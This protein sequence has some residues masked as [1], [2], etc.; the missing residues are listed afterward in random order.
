MKEY[1][2]YDIKDNELCV[3][4]GNIKEIADF[5]EC[6]KDS[7]RSWISN[8]KNKKRN[9]L[10]KKRYE[11]VE[12]IEVEEEK[13]KTIKTDK[14][15]FQEIIKAF[16]IDIYELM[17]KFPKYN[18]TKR[19]FN[20]DYNQEAD[21]ED[22]EWKQIGNLNYLVSNYGR[23]K[24]KTTKKLKQLKF[25]LY[26][27]QVLLWQNSKSY[28][29]TVSR[30]VAAMFIRPLKENERVFHKNNNIRDN[31]YKNLYIKSY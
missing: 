14:E 17:L 20:R 13:E 5:L 24:N 12:I 9:G 28:T 27:M 21:Y 6:S 31:Y 16:K 4:I 15:K 8:K 18:Y 22:E 30:L 29:I 10:I 1:G 19:E 2:L 11:L 26:G 7:L 3:F 25:Q 23:I